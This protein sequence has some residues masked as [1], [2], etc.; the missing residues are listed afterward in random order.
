MTHISFESNGPKLS[1]AYSIICLICLIRLA[2]KDV[3]FKQLS[4]SVALAYLDASQQATY[5]F[6]PKFHVSIES[7]WRIV[8]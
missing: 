5:E 3:T 1:L 4:K 8:V 6:I 2:S 7:Y